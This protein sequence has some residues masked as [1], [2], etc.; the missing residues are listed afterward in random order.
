MHIIFERIHVHN[1]KDQNKT[2][3]NAKICFFILFGLNKKNA[4]MT[5]TSI[6]ARQT[7]KTTNQKTKKPKNSHTNYPQQQ[8]IKIHTSIIFTV[9]KHIA[10][11]NE[12]YLFFISFRLV[13]TTNRLKLFDYTNSKRKTGETQRLAAYF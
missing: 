11:E 6:F 9:R 1:G 10:F 13:K 4:N 3:I 12:H 8:K 7:D 2:T 5:K